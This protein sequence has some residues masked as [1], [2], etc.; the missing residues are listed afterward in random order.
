MAADANIFTIA[1]AAQ[2]LGET[3]DRLWALADQMYPEDGL[4]WI[5]DT[6]G[7]QTMAFTSRGL[8]TLRDLIADQ[9]STES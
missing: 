1:L 8:E 5:H 6:D 4:V 9:P 2:M 7:R 3:E